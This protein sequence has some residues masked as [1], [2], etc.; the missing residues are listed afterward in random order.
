MTAATNGPA[1][2]DAGLDLLAPGFRVNS[3]A[4]RAAA[5]RHWYAPTPLGPA[6]LRYADCEALLHDR[7]FRQAG[8]DHLTVQG[9]SDGPVADMW[10]TVILNLEGADH[11]RL[12]R[13]V[14]SA[15]T[16]NV[17]E[18]LRRSMRTLVHDLVDTFA[19]LGQC[20]F[21]SAFADRYP[22]RIMF[23]LLGIPEGDHDLLL[24]WGKDLALVLGVSIAEHRARIESALA[25][26]YEMT[27]RLCAERLRH[28]GD[29][30]LSRFVLAAQDGDRLTTQELRSMVV[31]L[32][33]GGQDSTRSQ[34][35]LAL[36]T[37]AHHPRQWALLAEHPELAQRAT[38][39]VMRFSPTVP[40]IWRVATERVIYRDL[41]IAAGSRI[42]L[43]IGAAHREPA[44]F[45]TDGFDI[46]ARRP[47]QL[48]FGHGVHYCLGAALARA[49]LAEALPI[50]ARR[51]PGLALTK[52][53]SFRGDLS[54]FVGPEVLPISFTGARTVRQ[55]VSSVD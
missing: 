7:R 31:A 6:V 9:I 15:F 35:G 30:L 42:W 50:L 22:P 11:T 53:P 12:R 14:A 20:E 16:P 27:D 19:P 29:D 21:M 24:A 32:V 43:L 25:G 28:P 1:S 5:E 17:V 51:L 23:R 2:G 41:D 37:F 49:E 36:W 47:P 26:L 3:P 40:I 39:E 46:A 34:L 10:R 33:I 44:T 18:R 4:V 48:S 38:E 45:G 54:G 13:L 52:D 55:T 8:M